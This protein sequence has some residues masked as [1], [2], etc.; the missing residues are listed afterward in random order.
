MISSIGRDSI[1]TSIRSTLLDNCV[2]TL[3]VNTTSVSKLRTARTG[4]HESKVV[5]GI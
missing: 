4:D 5:S 2:I 3:E 1:A